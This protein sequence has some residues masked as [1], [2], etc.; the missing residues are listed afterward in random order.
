MNYEIV[1]AK[2]SPEGRLRVLSKAEMAKLLDT[3]QSGLYPVFRNS[4]LAV[5]NSGA[6]MDDGKELL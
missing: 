1:D 3:S 5:L 4:A 2:V 6:Y